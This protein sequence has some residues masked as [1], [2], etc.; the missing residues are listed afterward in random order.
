MWKK[1]VP[2]ILC[3]LCVAAA[4][5][6]EEPIDRT[7]ASLVEQVAKL[8]AADGA[9]GDMFG[10]SVSVSGDTAIAGAHQD[11]DA[12]H[13]SGSAYVFERDEGGPGNWGQVAKLTAADG[14]F[15]DWFGWSVSVS[16]TAAIVGAF[17]DDDAGTESGSAYIFERDEGGP[18]SWGQVAKLTAADDAAYDNFGKSVSVSGT[19]AIVGAYGDDDAGSYSGSAYVFE[20]DE[21]GPGNW[22]QV[23]KLTADDAAASGWFGW[24][25]SISGT[26][27]IV[28]ALGGDDAGSAYVFERDEGGPDN[29]GQVAKLTAD[30][31]ADYDQFGWSVSV[32]GTAAIIG[33]CLDDDAGRNSG[34]A[35]AFERDEGGSWGQVAKLTAD[36]GETEGWFGWSVSVSGTAAIVGAY[37]NEADSFSGSA[38]VFERDEGGPD[39]WGQVVK[40]TAADGAA[41]DHFGLSVSVSGG[42]AIAGAYGDDDASGSAYVFRSRPLLT[43]P[44]DVPAVSATLVDVPVDLTTGGNALASVAFSIDYDESCLSFDPTD[45]DAD[46][47]PDALDIPLPATFSATVFFDLGDTDGEIDIALLADDPATTTFTAGTVATVTFTPTCSAGATDSVIAPVAFSADPVPSFGDPDGQ[48]VFGDSVGGSVEIFDGLCGDCDADGVVSAADITACQLEAFDGDGTFWADTLDVVPFLGSPVGCD[49]NADTLVDAGDISCKARLTFG[50]TCGGGR[51]PSSSGPNLSLPAELPSADGLII[52]ATVSFEPGD[53]AVNSALFSLDY[54]E[55][56]LVFD[57]VPGAVRFLGAPVALQWA[58]FDSGDAGGEL[59]VVIADLSTVGVLAEGPLVELDLRLL[60]PGA[61]TIE[62]GVSFSVEPPASF[63][64]LEGRSVPGT[65]E[66]VSP[67]FADGFETGDGSA[68]LSLPLE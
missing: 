14:A 35:Y 24:S 43:I 25:V 37:G 16:G 8:T 52:T 10:I 38:Y 11:D 39:N 60:L 5:F 49:A 7:P 27:A 54:D 20:R 23:A 21:G 32:S 28:G 6:A 64:D 46:S 68:W 4:A 3:G 50:L 66:V 9:A 59:D 67:I 51:A 40:L 34:S 12:G 36:D 45:S 2:T 1:I 61:P 18:G 58:N 15:S 63:G 62:G 26:A 33:A 56:R 65:T 44:T 47:I 29:W 55:N 48:D 57:D 19:A 42:T 13:H 30:D 31:G 41:S 17:G 22:G 53:V